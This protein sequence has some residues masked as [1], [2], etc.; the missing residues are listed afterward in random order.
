MDLKEE[1]LWNTRQSRTSSCSIYHMAT[2]GQLGVV[3]QL[4]GIPLPRL[5][6]KPRENETIQS[7]S[8]RIVSEPWIL[9]FKRIWGP[10]ICTC[11]FDWRIYYN[12]TRWNPAVASYRKKNNSRPIRMNFCMNS[13]FL[14]L[15]LIYCASTTRILFVVPSVGLISIM[16]LRLAQELKHLK[17]IWRGFWW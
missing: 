11:S 10:K 9:D 16:I 8:E 6:T 5:N 4:R 12:T 15:R 14:L 17:S 1:C 13:P 2:Y 7:C 3:H